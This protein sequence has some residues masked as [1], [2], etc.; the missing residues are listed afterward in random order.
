LITGAA[1]ELRARSELFQLL[2]PGFQRSAECFDLVCGVAC[3]A[4]GITNLLRRELR[5]Q[6]S[7]PSCIRA[8][9]VVAEPAHTEPRRHF[10][11]QNIVTTVRLNLFVGA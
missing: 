10:R 6:I 7:Q 1:A 3:R 4:K 8:G 2:D 5:Q 11:E 9:N